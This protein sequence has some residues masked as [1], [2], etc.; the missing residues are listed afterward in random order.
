MFGTVKKMTEERDNSSENSR[1]RNNPSEPTLRATMHHLNY[2]RFDNAK[3]RSLVGKAM[4]D[5]I[6]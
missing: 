2:L 1:A 4:V 6:A 3:P 5:L